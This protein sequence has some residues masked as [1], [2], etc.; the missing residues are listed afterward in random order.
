VKGKPNGIGFTHELLKMDHQNSRYV[1]ALEHHH[2]AKK[3]KPVKKIKFV[4]STRT[5][6]TTVKEQMMEHPVELPK[7]ELVKEPPSWK[8]HFFNRQGHKKPFCYKLYGAPRLYQPGPTISMVKKEWRPKCV[9]LITHTYLRASSSED[10]YFDSG[11]FRHMTGVDKFLEYVRPYA[12]SYVTFG[13]GA[14]GKIVGT[15]NLVSEGSP[16]LDNVLLVKGLAANLISI[17]QLCDQGLSVNFSN[18]KCQII[19]GEGKL[20]M[21]GTTSKD[22]CY[23]WVSQEQA[24]I[25]SCMLSK[26]EEVR[27]WHQKL[28]HLNMQRMKKAISLEAIRGIPKL[29][30]TE[31]SICGEF[32]VGKQTQMSHPRLEHQGTSKVL[33]LHH[34]DLMGPM[35]VGNISGKRYVMVVVDD[36]SR[37]TWVNF[38]REKSYTFE[39]FKELCIQLQRE[40]D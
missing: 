33:E 23:L 9:G 5:Y 17:S 28:G 1:Q 3:G 29:E 22:N 40:K 20:S 32:Q 11:C 36:F 21:K 4:A 27:L 7:P 16:R 31:G 2:K 39:S 24:L 13:D 38:I 15:R 34:I 25:N 37:F 30:I 18:T 26:D 19:D 14:K 10:C 12:K 8:C 35:Q 6:S